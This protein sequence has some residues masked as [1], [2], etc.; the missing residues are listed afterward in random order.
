MKPKTKYKLYIAWAWCDHFDKSTEFT[1]QFMADEAKVEYDTAVNFMMN[2]TDEERDEWY[3]ANP[4][5][6]ADWSKNHILCPNPEC[7]GDLLVPAVIGDSYYCPTCKLQ[8]VEDVEIEP[9][10]YDEG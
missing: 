1:F 3:K 7:S 8:Y 2:N 10:G 9:E 6:L 4:Y 5:W